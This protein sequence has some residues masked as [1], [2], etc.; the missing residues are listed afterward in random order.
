MRGCID[1]EQLRAVEKIKNV[2]EKDYQLKRA[3]G[4]GSDHFTRIHS[5]LRKTSHAT[6]TT[7]T[8]IH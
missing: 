5:L 1:A 2:I 4:F 6:A 3:C 7:D 8:K